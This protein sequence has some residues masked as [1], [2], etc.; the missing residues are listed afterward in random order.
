M[1][2]D[3][4]TSENR[5]D[6]SI[7]E[8]LSTEDQSVQCNLPQ[9]GVLH[10]DSF[11]ENDRII[12]YYTSFKNYKQ[13]MLLYSVLGPCV[14][15]L[16]VCCHLKSQDQLFM[17]LI[18]LRL[19]KDDFELSILF[20]ISEKLVS[21]VFI[22]WLNF[23]FYQ[24][25]EI[26]FWPSRQVVSETMPMHFR[27][28]FPTTR[29]IIDATEV[30]IQKPGHVGNQSASF[31]SYKN[32]NTLKVLV[33]CTPRGL[34]SFVSDAYAGSTSDRQ[35][36]ERSDLM[37]KSLFSSGDSIM[38]D[39]GFNVQDLFAAKDVHVNIPSFLKG[40]SQLTAAEVVKD[41]RIAAKRN[42]H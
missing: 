19:A 30:A 6:A 3:N 22:C 29:V 12:L 25:S 13:F 24:L 16:S 11:A 28:Q 38:A 20:D 26:D 36:C 32:T 17:T 35:I 37:N 42:S 33:G 18:K 9:R 8:S 1:E 4:N 5:Q 2:V 10:V 23:L 21:K 39:R 14:N 34:I 7:S 31:S 27:A 41:R 15:Q 40:K